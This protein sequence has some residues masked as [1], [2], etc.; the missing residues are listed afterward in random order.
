MGDWHDGCNALSD[1]CV[2]QYWE[3]NTRIDAV[4]INLS[5]LHK[6]DEMW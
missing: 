3:I 2:K 1:A 5:Q 4:A 6:I